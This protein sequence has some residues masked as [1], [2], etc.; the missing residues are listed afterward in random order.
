MAWGVAII[1]IATLGYFAMRSDLSPRLGALGIITGMKF[2]VLM[3]LLGRCFW[4]K[5]K[6]RTRGVESVKAVARRFRSTD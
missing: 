3:M 1:P 5:P 2:C 6:R 4:R